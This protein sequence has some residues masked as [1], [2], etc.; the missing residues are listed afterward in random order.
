VI[1]KGGKTFTCEV[2]SLSPAGENRRYWRTS[3]IKPKRVNDDLIAYVFP[4][5]TVQ[6]ITMK[7]HLEL[8]GV[9]GVRSFV[10]GERKRKPRKDARLVRAW[11]L[12]HDNLDTWKDS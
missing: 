6:V 3:A 5:G 10:L 12:S 7:L 8:S 4:D 1:S 11:R 9:T 2:K